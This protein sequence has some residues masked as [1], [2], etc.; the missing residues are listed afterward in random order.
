METFDAIN[1]QDFDWQKN[2]RLESMS[3][4]LKLL[5]DQSRLTI[6]TS[7]DLECRS[8]GDIAEVTGLN[9]SNVSFHLRLLRGGGLVRPERRGSHVYYCLPNAGFLP[10]LQQLSE[11]LE[12]RKPNLYE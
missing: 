7:L 11:W 2:H 8:V 9:Q 4:T 10:I 3:E 12:T 1:K 5:A 6:L